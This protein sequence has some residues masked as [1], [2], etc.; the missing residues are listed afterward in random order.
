MVALFFVS[1][2]I[3]AA[4][5]TA[6][7]GQSLQTMIAG[8]DDG[9]EIFLPAGHYAGPINIS[10]S[11]HIRGQVGTVID[12]GGVSHGLIIAAPRVIIEGLAIINWGH[13]LTQQ[14]AG[15]LVLNTASDS[16]IKNNQLTGPGFGIWLDSVQRVQVI[17]NK[18]H[19]DP[20][21]RSQD[22][23]NG[24][25]L[26]N[27]RDVLVQANTVSHTR[28]GI[29]IDN[30]SH[31]LLKDNQ[32]SDL[33]YGIHYMYAYDNR[34]EGNVTRNTR[35]GYALMQS[36]RLTVIA[37]RSIEDDN[38]GILMNNIT[39]S[40]LRHNRVEHIRQPVNQQQGQISGGDG[41]AIFVYNS[42]FNQFL[43]NRF[44]SSD[45]GIHLTAG[46]ED[47]VVAGNAFINNRQQVK[48]VATRAQEWSKN[49]R[50]NYWSNYLGWDLNDDGIGDTAFEPN[51]AM[52]RLLWR[53]PAARPLMHSPSV[54]S[55]RWAQRQFPVFRPQGVK[56]S[57]PLMVEPI[58]P[59]VGT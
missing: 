14:D 46:S 32:I 24:I 35:T 2:D 31:C 16:V 42:Q 29:Y 59:Q 39:G 13:N 1:A 11:V 20:Q 36:K 9:D 7:P 58:T 52:D 6:S 40:L 10:R 43:D 8:A 25:H 33:R 21:L 38:Y 50:G 57:A 17:N 15:I 54:L 28:D 4:K 48:Y 26:F 37:N 18:V 22:R 23:G 19:G 51:D 47:N 27:V 41:K 56:D 44:V 49:G 55:L 3:S 5:L 12:G 34:I 45:I 53:Y 30:S